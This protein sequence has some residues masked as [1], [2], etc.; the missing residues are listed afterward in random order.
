M[1]RLLDSVDSGLK[2]PIGIKLTTVQK[3][4][5]LAPSVLQAVMGPG[6]TLKEPQWDINDKGEMRAKLQRGE[7]SSKE[8]CLEGP[9]CRLSY[10]V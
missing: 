1:F 7:N 9:F 3:S 2:L 4:C 6:I 5:K 8:S 10:T